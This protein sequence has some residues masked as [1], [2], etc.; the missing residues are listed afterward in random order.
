M[1][2]PFSAAKHKGSI[3]RYPGGAMSFFGARISFLDSQTAIFFLLPS[4]SQDISF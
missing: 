1:M 4:L 3:I 2:Q